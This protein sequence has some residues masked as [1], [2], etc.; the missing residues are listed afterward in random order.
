MCSDLYVFLHVVF[1]GGSEQIRRSPRWQESGDTDVGTAISEDHHSW[2]A[3]ECSHHM[4]CPEYQP[5]LRAT[6]G[7]N[8][9][10]YQYTQ[11]NKKA[12]KLRVL[13]A[14]LILSKNSCVLEAKPRLK[15]AKLAQFQ[16]ISP[17]IS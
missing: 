13:S 17:R 10:T 2:L 1:F 15:S 5:S 12:H 16:L 14:T 3:R 7:D 6:A 9:F 4:S 8:I 11:G